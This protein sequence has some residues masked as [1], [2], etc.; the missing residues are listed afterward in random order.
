M[1]NITQEFK[2]NSIKDSD[3]NKEEELFSINDNKD[4]I[5]SNINNNKIEIEEIEEFI[6]AEEYLFDCSR[7]NDIDGLK[8][9]LS[10]K[11][12]NLNYQNDNKNSALRK[13]SILLSFIFNL[14][15]KI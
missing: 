7:F 8:L 15:V 9:V 1:E 13:Y 6:T 10:D 5:S 4:N 11:S 2:I 3:V 12:L 14:L